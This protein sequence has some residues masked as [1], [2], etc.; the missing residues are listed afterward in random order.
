MCMF[1]LSSSSG[2]R[3]PERL[4]KTL[5]GMALEAMMPGGAVA[6]PG[7]ESTP[8][9]SFEFTTAPFISDADGAWHASF[10]QWEEN[11]VTTKVKE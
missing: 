8:P 4:K 9:E 3:K 11:D 5:L 6:K 2:W 1:C 10:D 7:A